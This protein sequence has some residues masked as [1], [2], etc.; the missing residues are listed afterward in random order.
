MKAQE[1][2]NQLKNNPTFTGLDIWVDP[3]GIVE[4][5]GFNATPDWKTTKAKL[6]SLGFK[7]GPNFGR[8][9]ADEEKPAPR[10]V[11]VREPETETDHKYRELAESCER[12]AVGG[13]YYR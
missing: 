2:A 11:Q 12:T 10:T 6:E 5:Y 7:C 13:E 9:E 3:R 1:M 8:Y 4:V